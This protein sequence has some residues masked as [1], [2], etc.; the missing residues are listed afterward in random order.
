MSSQELRNAVASSCN[1]YHLHLQLRDRAVARPFVL[2]YSIHNL[3]LPKKYE[4]SVVGHELWHLT[5][6]SATGPKRELLLNALKDELSQSPNRESVEEFN[7]SYALL[8]EALAYDA[9]LRLGSTSV[10]LADQIQAT[11]ENDKALADLVYS[12]RRLTNLVVPLVKQPFAPSV[13]LV[14][15]YL[16]ECIDLLG[17]LNVPPR[18][19]ATAFKSSP[20]TF[21][22]RLPD[23]KQ[24]NWTAVTFS[25]I[26]SSL[27]ERVRQTGRVFRLVDVSD[28]GNVQAFPLSRIRT[29]FNHDFFIQDLRFHEA[30]LKLV[31]SDTSEL[32]AEYV[33]A[34]LD[35]YGVT[36]PVAYRTVDSLETATPKVIRTYVQNPP[37]EATFR[38]LEERITLGQTYSDKWK[39]RLERAQLMQESR[40]YI[41]FLRLLYGFSDA[42]VCP[43]DRNIENYRCTLYSRL[44][45]IIV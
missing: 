8:W 34:I 16:H 35:E 41:R 5:G 28:L 4:L 42:L 30:L 13:D 45:R 44:R 10:E 37:H 23:L 29:A 38:R 15:G 43:D 36:S 27:P 39:V 20:N 2:T 7:R 40:R 11:I 21:E 33:G 12:V 26:L 32:L 18:D 3:D 14:V 19:I 17:R 1:K 31:D 24:L 22:T 6:T 9:Q 25:S